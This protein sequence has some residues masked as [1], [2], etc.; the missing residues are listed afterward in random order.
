MALVLKRLFVNYFYLF[1]DL[2]DERVNELG[3]FLMS[4]PLV[5]AAILFS[6]LHFTY[7]LGPRL[8]KNRKP[9][10]LKWVLITFNLTQIISNTYIAYEAFIE[11]WFY[12]NWKCQP[13]TYSKTPRS[14]WMLR[15]YHFFFLMKVLD[16]FDTVFFVLRKKYQQVTFLHVYH[17]FGMTLLMWL[18]VKFFSG[19]SGTWVGLINGIVHVVMYLYYLLSSIDKSWKTSVKFKK[20]ITQ[21][22]MV[23]F[24]TFIIIY[25]KL[26]FQ[27]CAYPKI[28]SFFFVPQ[29]VF[30]LLLFGN[31]YKKT[32]LKKNR[33]NELM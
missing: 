33:G 13:I 14:L 26:L 2:A 4:S 16:L 30:M 24:L 19:G 31:F 18:V 1:D 32:Y 23:Q 8:M 7:K 28:A 22:Q 29:N 17:H 25:A 11:I 15:M 21:V 3:L 9:F 12:M 20:F 10:E 6:Y 27:D 5:I